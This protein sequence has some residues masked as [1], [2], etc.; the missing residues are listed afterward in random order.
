LA[1]RN[2]AFSKSLLRKLA[3]WAVYFIVSDCT[4]ESEAAQRS[5]SGTLFTTPPTAPAAQATIPPSIA[6]CI[7]HIE[8]ARYWTKPHKNRLILL[9]RKEKKIL[10]KN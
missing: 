7:M 8:N 1:K 2:T 4:S 9:S 10:V 5:L 3:N 6:S